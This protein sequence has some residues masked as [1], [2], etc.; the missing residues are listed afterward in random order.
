MHPTFAEMYDWAFDWDPEF[1]FATVDALLRTL[2]VQPLGIAVDA[3]CG[4]G[5]FLPCLLKR[6]QR[7][8]AVEPDPG[9]FK[10]LDSHHMDNS[11]GGQL[12]LANVSLESFS[13]AHQADVVLAMT[14]T[15]SYVMPETRCA[16]FLSTV[17]SLLKPGGVF[18]ADVGVW[19][20]YFG[21]MRAECW[22]SELQNGWLV[23]ASYEAEL[24]LQGDSLGCSRKVEVLTFEAN[25]TGISTLRSSRQETL[26]FTH[27]FLLN[28]L[29][30]HGLVFRGAAIPG[31]SE[32]LAN[33]LPTP[34][35]LMYCFAKEAA[36]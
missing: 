2:R 24:T 31:R 15:L 6:F 32:I 33:P 1:E 25:R 13:M 16:R 9:M 17:S 29:A 12:L 26:A 36:A 7:V 3:G 30:S 22:N 20:G 28:M 27:A 34:K 35:R 23:K 4:T 10:V 8:Y 14:D 18:I 21:E 11:L 19:A 5:R